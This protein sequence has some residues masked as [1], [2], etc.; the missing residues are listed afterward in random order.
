MVR[1]Q[2]SNCERPAR[3]KRQR[4]GLSMVSVRFG[5]FRQRGID[6]MRVRIGTTPRRPCCF[7]LPCALFF[8]R[9]HKVCNRR[10]RRLVAIFRF[11]HWCCSLLP[12]PWPTP[13]IE[14]GPYLCWPVSDETPPL[15]PMAKRRRDVQDYPGNKL[16]VFVPPS[17]RHRRFDR[18]PIACRN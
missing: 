11:L 17:R 10:E 2:D 3:R 5:T 6:G 12:E 14:R 13:L 7:I 9:F 15:F 16:S 8:L 1:R 18:S 4:F